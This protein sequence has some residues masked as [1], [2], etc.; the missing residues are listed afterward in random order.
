MK[1]KIAI[2]LCLLIIFLLTTACDYDYDTPTTH[3]EKSIYSVGD[4]VIIRDNVSNGILGRIIITGVQIIEDE[5]FTVRERYGTDSEGNPLYTEQN[6]EAVVQMNY[7]ASTI[8]AQDRISESNFTMYDANGNYAEKNPKIF[9]ETAPTEYNYV[10]FAVKEKG[11]HVTV[12][13]RFHG[14]Q[15]SVATIEAKYGEQFK[16][17]QDWDRK[18][19][20][21]TETGET[22]VVERNNSILD[23]KRELE[24]ETVKLEEKNAKLKSVCVLLSVVDAVFIAVAIVLVV[25]TREVKKV[26]NEPCNKTETEEP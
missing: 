12:E 18:E 4:E 1:K 26:L 15:Y 20:N 11:D 9:Y 13:F 3:T 21:T 22:V 19:E 5:P 17:D 10:V 14:E 2:A 23:E 6:Y 16:P 24:K 8:D 7:V 25:K